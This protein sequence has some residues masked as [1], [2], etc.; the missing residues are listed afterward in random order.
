MTGD[1]PENPPPNGRH[2][3]LLERVTAGVLLLVVALLGWILLAAYQPEAAR[4]AAEEVQV[5]VALGMLSA[6][7]VLVSVVALL[8]TR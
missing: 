3:R 8:H 7:L 6:A 1:G 4:W 5:L 2:F